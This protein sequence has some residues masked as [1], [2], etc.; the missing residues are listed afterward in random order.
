MPPVATG[1]MPPVLEKFS[2]SHNQIFMTTGEDRNKSWFKR[3]Q[4]CS[5][6]RLSLGDHRAMKFTLYLLPLP[7]LLSIVFLANRSVQC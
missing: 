2:L 5:V 1:L 6:W 3:W 4:I 7:I